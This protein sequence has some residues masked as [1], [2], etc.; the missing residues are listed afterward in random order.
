MLKHAHPL[1]KVSIVPRGRALGS[2]WYLPNERVLIT[3]S[4]FKD[5][6]CSILGGRA[7]EE[8]IF[9][10]ISSGAMDDLER[11][12]K[13]AYS[14]VAFLGMSKSLPNLSFYDSSGEVD[15]TFQKPYSERTAELIDKEVQNIISEQYERAKNILKQN[16]EKFSQLAE[17]LLKKEVIFTDDVE[18]ILGKR[19]FDENQAEVIEQVIAHQKNRKDQEE[20][21]NSQDN[22]SN[23]Q[24]NPTISQ[25]PQ[26][27]EQ[28]QNPDSDQQIGPAQNN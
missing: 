8:V 17:L 18:K 2:A 13:R 19:Q 4:Q 22:S 1:I 21:Q 3:E 23:E 5:E 12:T 9:N 26:N 10:E 15:Y 6:I 27:P 25:Q 28:T 11:A 14:M 16:L 24:Q 7:A 20:Q